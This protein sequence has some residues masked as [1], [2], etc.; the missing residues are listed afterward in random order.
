MPTSDFTEPAPL[1]AYLADAPEARR[2]EESKQSMP[3]EAPQSEAADEGEEEE[4]E[5]RLKYTRLGGDAPD[6]LRGALLNYGFALNCSAGLNY[7]F[8]RFD[9]AK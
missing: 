9:R 6:L 1:R 5:P 7:D 4:E 2:T 8:A 3:P